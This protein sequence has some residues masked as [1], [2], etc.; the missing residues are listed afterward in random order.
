MTRDYLK[1]K[2]GNINIDFKTKKKKTDVLDYSGE[3]K[4]ER[5]KSSSRLKTRDTCLYI[6]TI[7]SSQVLK[8]IQPSCS[9]I[10]T[11]ILPMARS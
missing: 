10:V 2:E 11:I 3:A 9:L 4:F 8:A 6:D 7:L 1:N 5:I